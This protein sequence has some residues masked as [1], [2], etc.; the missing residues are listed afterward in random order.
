MVV[1]A[2]NYDGAIKVARECP[3]VVKPGTSVEIRE[4][5]SP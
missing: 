2:E 1:A 4:I 5:A 3:G